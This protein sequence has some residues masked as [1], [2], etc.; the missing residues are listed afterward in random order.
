MKIPNNIINSKK[1]QNRVA[2]FKYKDYKISLS[3]LHEQ[4]LQ[5]YDIILLN[6]GTVVFC[7]DRIYQYDYLRKYINAC[8]NNSKMFTIYPCEILG[9]IQKQDTDDYNTLLQL[10]L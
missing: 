10:L 5:P 7:M 3:C 4:I 1:Y 2:I 6:D 8:Y 9:I